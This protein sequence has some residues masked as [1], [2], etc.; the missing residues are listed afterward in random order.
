VANF[1][2]GDWSFA[3]VS[4]PASEPVTLIQAKQALNIDSSLTDFD[5][6]LT[7]AIEAARDYLEGAYDVR[8]MPQTIEMTLQQFPR[9]DRIR[10]PLGPVQAC[11]YFTLEDTGGNLTPLTVG[12][13]GAGDNSF[14]LL[15]RFA[16]KPAE[17][18]LPFG[19]VW[20]PVVLQMADPIRIGLRLGWMTGQ[21]P[22][23]L[24]LPPKLRQALYLLLGH[25]FNNR[26]AVSLG[27]LNLT[28]AVDLG[29][30]AL[31]STLGF[32][33]Y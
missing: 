31:M 1:P 25:F 10:I 22:E 7:E 33:R 8:I 16:R 29:V 19:K 2:Q 3:L 12:K 20:P 27:T 32:T 15:S 11:T 21:S 5:P 13:G 28:K 26:S 17:I 4:P 24:P 14:D 6:Y 30:D 18:C 9:A 23:T